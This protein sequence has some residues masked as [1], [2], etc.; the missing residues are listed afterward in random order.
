MSLSRRVAGTA[1]A[2][3]VLASAARILA[4]DVKEHRPLVFGSGVSLVQVPVFVSTKSGAAAQGLTAD[5]FQVEEDGKPVKVVSF[6][7]VDT[8]SVEQQEAI[9]EAPARTR[10]WGAGSIWW[11]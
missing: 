9:R 6:R 11:P 3:V 1:F 10:D 2:L 4:D 5:D 7:F 8:T